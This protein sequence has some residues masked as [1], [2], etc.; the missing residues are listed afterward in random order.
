MRRPRRAAVWA[1]I[2]AIAAISAEPA[3]AANSAD[4]ETFS[5]SRRVDPNG[6]SFL[7]KTRR[8]SPTG[9][10]YPY[11][12][13]PS[14]GLLLGDWKLRGLAEFGW[15]E[16]WGGANEA[17]YEEFG[18]HKDGAIDAARFEAHH[19][20]SGAYAEFGASAIGR[21][22]ASAFLDAGQRGL[23]RVRAFYDELPHRY[24]NDARI[25]FD[26]AGS[27]N[28]TL[29]AGLVAGG[30][31]DAAI[32]AAI[33]ERSKSRL[34]VDRQ[35]SGVELQ[36][37]APNSSWKLRAGY[38]N[39]E[40]DGERPFGGAI[41]FAFQSPAIGSVVETVEPIRSRTHD[42]HGDLQVT[43]PLLQ[44]DLGYEGSVFDNRVQSLTWD[45]PFPNTNVD[46]GRFALAP[47]NLQ[48]RLHAAL[49][50]PP[51]PAHGRW[52]HTFSWV[53][54]RQN[55]RLLAPTINGAFP[56]W[57][58]PATS[59]SRSTARARV[60]NT[61]VTSTLRLSP[62]RPVS[63]GA[64]LRFQRRDNHTKYLAYNPSIDDYGYVIE[65]GSFGVQSRYRAVPFD[66][67]RLALE[68][69]ASVQVLSRTQL[70]LE[71]DYEEVTREERARRLT[72]DHRGRV[73]V[74]TRRIPRTTVRVAYEVADRGGSSFHR[75]RDALFY[76][77]GPPDFAQPGIGTPQRSLASFEQ[78]D[79]AD[80]LSN[81]ANARVNFALA[82]IADLALAGGVRDDDYALRHGLRRG[83]YADA[84]A[85]LTVRPAPAFDAHAFG[86]AEWRE[87]ELDT[88][89]SATFTGTDFTPGG[90][91]FPLD[92]AWDLRTRERSLSAGAGLSARPWKPL[93]LRADY[94]LLLSRERLSYD[95]ASI[96]ALAPGVTA[97]DAGTSFPDLRNLDH[98]VDL[99]AR[100][101]LAKWIAVRALY[102]F[103]HSTISNFHQTNLVPRIGHALY[104]GHV[105]GDFTAH[106]VGG[107]VQLSF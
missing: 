96:D 74:S 45:N 20:P 7:T 100:V 49:T 24:A 12:F 52:T 29:P 73:S 105:D 98:L 15:I 5:L 85:E 16:S 99:S 37:D 64:K 61:L 6:L 19:A 81:G 32:D 56:S 93:E 14:P 13:E 90:P 11:P 102:R 1:S 50:F 107:S 92:H 62:I 41:R 46:R 68:G 77:A 10:L 94:Q 18:D 86:G 47:D 67:E 34:A 27:Q 33:A 54:A 44:M 78:Y 28:L 51:L 57:I 75:E 82:E 95:Y 38:R 43:D 31:P 36:L 2:G 66:S 97:V 55:E 21:D 23:L 106:V 83:R 76:S 84:N 42:F 9:F 63:V 103:Q 53:S 65:D 8:R 60:D 59:L 4:D 48:H 35:K 30:N 88:L 79:L 25:L 40:A 89:D 70:A 58:D 69:S 72:R 101:E 17:Y 71:Y 3:I 104:L 80:R 26:G 87:R 91:V 39:T 22:D